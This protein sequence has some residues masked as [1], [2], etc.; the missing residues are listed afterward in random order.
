MALGHPHATHQGH[1]CLG[2]AQPGVPEGFLRGQ[3]GAVA[4]EGEGLVEPGTSMDAPLQPA[5]TASGESRSPMQPASSEQV[6]IPR[7]SCLG[8]VYSPRQWTQPRSSAP[9][10][11][12]R[13]LSPRPPRL[14]RAFSTGVL[15][16]AQVFRDKA[17]HLSLSAPRLGWC[18]HSMHT[19]TIV[20]PAHGRHR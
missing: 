11:N 10:S 2:S 1:R 8:R 6:K 14:S 18:R 20:F 5:H 13:S 9:S 16:G 4:R 19:P 3:G 17:G 12:G 7:C 15:Q